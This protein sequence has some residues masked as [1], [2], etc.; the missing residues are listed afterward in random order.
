[1]F[2]SIDPPHNNNPLQLRSRPDPDSM[3][4]ISSMRRYVWISKRCHGGC[5]RRC[6]RH[7]GNSNDDRNGKGTIPTM[8]VPYQHRAVI[9]LFVWR[10]LLPL[11]RVAPLGPPL[12]AS[13]GVLRLLLRDRR[14]I[15]CC[16]LIV[17]VI[18]LLLL[19]VVGYFCCCSF[20]SVLH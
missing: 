9:L 7:C 12:S 14:S 19:I 2:G 3:S 20:V 8:P 17:M 10:L 18:V 13:A 5:R 11:R 4:G 6:Q 15:F 16:C 1:M